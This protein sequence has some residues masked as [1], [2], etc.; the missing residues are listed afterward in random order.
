M[1][2]N[3]GSSCEWVVDRR[4]ARQLPRAPLSMRRGRWYRTSR[5]S[6]TPV[7]LKVGGQTYRVVASADETELKRLAEVVDARL[8]LLTTPGRQVSPQTLL[9]AA[10]AL[11]HDLEE[12]RARRV[13]VEARAKEMLSS[14]LERIDSVLESTAPDASE[15][16]PADADADA[17]E[18]PL[19]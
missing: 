2:L 1:G 11:A 15:D 13:R 9:L 10:L 8:R 19:T 7:E 6:G 3:P 16:A 17:D 14:V 12:E 5:M 4:C 18:A